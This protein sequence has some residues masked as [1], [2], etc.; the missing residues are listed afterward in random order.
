MTRQNDV[1][2]TTLDIPGGKQHYKF[3]VDG[4]WILDAKNPLVEDDGMGNLNSVLF[5][6]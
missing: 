4:D 1:W 3:I 6:Y 2:T 5:V